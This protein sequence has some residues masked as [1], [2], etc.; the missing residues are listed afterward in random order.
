MIITRTPFRISFAGG[1]SDLEAFYCQ[2]PG[3][4]LSTAID[5]Y[6]YL[7]VMRRFGNNFRISY[8]RTELVETVDEI[9]HS[10]VRECL[11][12]L[13]IHHGLEIVSMADIPAQSGLGSSSSFAVGL[14][15]ALYASEGKLVSADRLAEH[16]CEIEIQRL[17]EPIGKQDQYIAAHGGLQLIQFN[18]DGTV[19]V[20][21][22]VC[23][24]GTREELNDR[25]MMFFTGITRN[26]K[27]VLQKQ[28]AGTNEKRPALR[29]MCQIARDLRDVLTTG[30][31]LNAFG[32]L[33]H[34]AWE[35][36]RSVEASI[37]NAVIDEYYERARRAGALGG[38]LLGAGGGGFLL[39]YCEPHL[40]DRV[41]EELE[42][43]QEV[44]FRFDPQGSKI[45]YVGEDRSK[46]TP[47]R[48]RDELRRTL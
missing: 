14:L 25:L 39:L 21:P 16:A 33:L 15:H 13:E 44:P 18:P 37:S 32:H 27:D 4:V 20:D 48:K 30:K 38:K 28:S 29:R 26:A 17:K 10:I 6:M 41:R 31:D 42:E 9:E 22:V 35:A 47:T 34:E 40:Q 36:K 19:F 8:S 45:I 1:G 7:T 23:P 2:E 11:K 12:S 43:L 46:P 3:V 5:K 24:P